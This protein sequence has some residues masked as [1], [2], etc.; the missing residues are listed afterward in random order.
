M[1]MSEEQRK[2]FIK[3]LDA[4]IVELYLKSTP[5]IDIRKV[6]VS[7]DGKVISWDHKIEQSEFDLQM[8]LGYE[9]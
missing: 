9:M 2:D 7:K 6:D 8:G 5:S 3:R 1:C 4:C